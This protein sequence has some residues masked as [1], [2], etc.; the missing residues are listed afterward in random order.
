M[1]CTHLQ[2]W[3]IGSHGQSITE[4]FRRCFGEI[5]QMAFLPSP[6]V[7]LFIGG[8]RLLAGRTPSVG[9]QTLI[10]VWRENNTLWCYWIGNRQS[11][12]KLLIGKG[13]CCCLMMWEGRG[14]MGKF[15][16]ALFACKAPYRST[17]NLEKDWG[18]SIK[19]L[20]IMQTIWVTYTQ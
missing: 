4:G 13:P 19:S 7:P 17:Y 14:R 8:T 15:G 10:F 6:A 20:E 3:Y 5:Q 2:L 18:S 11:L 1:S 12:L 9:F 16:P